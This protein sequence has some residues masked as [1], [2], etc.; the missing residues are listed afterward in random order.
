VPQRRQAVL[1]RNGVHSDLLEIELTKRK[2]PFVK[3]GGL[4]F[5]EVAHVK[6]LLA[7]LRWADNPL[8]ELAAF[9]VLQLLPGFGPANARK[10]VEHFIA[11]GRS[12]AS[13]R[14]FEPPAEAK[15]PWMRFCNLLEAIAGHEKPWPG[16]VRLVRDWYKPHLE[17]IYDHV[18][19]RVGDIDQLEALSSQYPT[20]DRFLAELTLDPPQAT[21]DIAA[22]ALQDEDYLVLSTVHS[23]KGM[24]W[25]TVYV[26]N[27]VEGSF[28]NEFAALK[29]ELLEEE[30]RLL[31]VA[32]TR[33]RDEII[34][35]QPLKFAVTS[36][37]PKS[38]AHV[39]GGRSRFMT[40]KVLKTLEASTFHGSHLGEARL[41]EP[42]PSVV[43]VTTRLR[44][45]F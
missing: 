6:D 20:R 24:E 16:Q 9:R 34:L 14:S 3:Y 11:A 19:T 39:Y 44:Q 43:D 4:R 45:L 7:I 37:S 35:V 23:A 32:I 42:A 18:H 27:L 1:Y 38:D 13:L 30:R 2:I 36:Q 25:D 10:A 8:N 33:A 31:Y 5:L 22:Q 28:P 40:E 12:F 15:L 26:L 17:R 41:A 29:D 21:S